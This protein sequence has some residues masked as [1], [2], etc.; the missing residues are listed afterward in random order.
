MFRLAALTNRNPASLELPVSCARLCP[1]RTL[2]QAACSLVAGARN[3]RELADESYSSLNSWSSYSLTCIPRTGSLHL[4]C[5]PTLLP[6]ECF[7][8]STPLD[9]TISGIFDSLPSIFTAGGMVRI[10]AGTVALICR[11]ETAG[12]HINLSPRLL[13]RKLCPVLCPPY[14]QKP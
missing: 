4:K 9:K 14:N 7:S 3:F 5:E 12:S 11:C 8:G 6:V 1:V 13:A 2:A 10:C